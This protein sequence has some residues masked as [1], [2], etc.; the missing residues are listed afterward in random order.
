M[1]IPYTVLESQGQMFTWLVQ[2]IY[3]HA[4]YISNVCLYTIDVYLNTEV[5][6]IPKQY[7]DSYTTQVTALKS[8]VGNVGETSKSMLD[9]ER[10][11]STPSFRAPPKPH[12]CALPNYCWRTTPREKARGERS[13]TS[14][15]C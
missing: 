2:V 10:K 4:K 8:T 11:I 9:F 6:V 15:H 3:A 5:A 12:E 7:I 13:A 14:R 1:D